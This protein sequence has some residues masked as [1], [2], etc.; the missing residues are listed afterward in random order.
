MIIRPYKP[1]LMKIRR[2]YQ[3]LYVKLPKDILLLSVAL[4]RIKA[5]SLSEPIS[6][7]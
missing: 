7:S 6:G 1:N 4:N 3:A 5:L 2:K